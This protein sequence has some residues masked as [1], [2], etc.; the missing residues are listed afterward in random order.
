MQN[1][2][3]PDWLQEV[4]ATIGAAIA[5]GWAFISMRDARRVRRDEH[6]HRNRKSAD[7]DHDIIIL[8]GEEIQRLKRE[9]K[10]CREKMLS[11][12]DF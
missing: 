3:L 6:P 12:Q 5:G 10:K 7:Y 4:A 8:Q 9:L 11:E 1:P 2:P